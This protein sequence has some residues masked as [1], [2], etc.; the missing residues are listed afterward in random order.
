MQ[1]RSPMWRPRFAD[2]PGERHACQSLCS[3][4]GCAAI[5]IRRRPAKS[6]Q[7]RSGRPDPARRYKIAAGEHGELRRRVHDFTEVAVVYPLLEAQVRVKRPVRQM[8]AHLRRQ[9]SA[10]GFAR[11]LVKLS[12]PGVV[13]IQTAG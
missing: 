9:E 7:S 5:L 10:F 8:C 1:M 11:K 13:I 6:A 4:S 2:P 12:R 3:R